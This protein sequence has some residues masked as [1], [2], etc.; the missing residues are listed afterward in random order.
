MIDRLVDLDKELTGGRSFE[1]IRKE[2]NGAR[3][4]LKHAN[5]PNEDEVT[6][7]PGEAIAMLG[8]A[9]VNYVWLTNSA[10]PAMLRV[11][12]QLIELHPDVAR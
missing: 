6:V 4:S 1:T 9:V 5:D 10:T 12:D 11:Y 3:N 8:R 2:V 7:E